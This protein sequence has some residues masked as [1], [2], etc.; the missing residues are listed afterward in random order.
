MCGVASLAPPV[1]RLPRWW[2]ITSVRQG[3]KMALA[4]CA[5]FYYAL[6][7]QFDSPGWCIF[8][9]VVLTLAQYVGAIAEKSALRAIGTVA[10]AL[11]GVWLIG[12]HG[13]NPLFVMIGC[14]VMAA[15]GT[16]MFGGNF[17]PYVFFLSALTTVVVVNNSMK[18]PS[19]AWPIGVARVEE[20]CVGILASMIV[21]SVLWPRYARVEFRN[22]FRAALRDTGRIAI[23]RSKALLEKDASDAGEE[24][25]KKLELSFTTRMN[26][27]RLLIRYGQRE[28]QYFRRKLP[29]RMRMMG[30]LG[31]C[32]E[33][34]VSLG[35]RLPEKS[36]YRDLIAG[37]L[38]RLHE[39]LERE[40]ED[41][42]THADEVTFERVNPA[43]LEAAGEC[44]RRLRE[45]IGQGATRSIPIQE[46]MDFSAHMVALSDIVARL[47]VLRECAW[48][49]HQTREVMAPTITRKPER[50]KL[51]AFWI[52][53]GIKG[54]ITATLALLY[55]NW[56][57]PPGGATI[58]FAAWL[59]TAL[60]RTYPGGQGD[61]GAFAYVVRI[62]LAGL[63]Y[64]ALL[65]VVTPFLADYFVFN[66][67]LI[68][69]L[70]WLG[71]SIAEQGGI[72]LYAQTG[73]LFFVGTISANPQEPV[74]FQAI[75][76]IYFGVVIA[77]VLS[78]FIQRLLWPLL[79]QREIRRLFAEY[80]ACCRALLGQAGEKER[81]R[82]LD[83]IA[84]IP[85]EAASWIKVTTTPEYPP[86]ETQ[87]LL[88]LL[89]TAQRLGYSIVS[90]HKRTTVEIPPELWKPLEAGVEHV[91]AECR[92]ALLILEEAFAQGRHGRAPDSQ[93]PIFGCLN[94]P[95][96]SLR[97]RYLTGEVQFPQA[98]P[99]L[100][101]MD[102]FEN[103]SRKIDQCAAQ[104]KGL[105]LERYSGDYAL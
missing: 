4:G 65:L 44:D 104:L 98:I 81:E 66:M 8:T 10:G 58:P 9:V 53:N 55:V 37:E 75:A 49:I 41:L 29:V 22:A 87:K 80:F 38:L 1:E 36:R 95:L 23:A 46:A 67:F 68:I 40:F 91:E 101:A 88:D 31:A 99:F 24:E 86:G 25:M 78:S 60:S 61:R 47:K 70:F 33:A 35:Q 50:F 76:N 32:F 3:L 54:G 45:L 52:R 103:C 59:F 72:S 57:N 15:F 102:F 16:A 71:Y 90:A 64:A 83:R 42:T 82:L 11:V 2:E 21:T 13:N 85:S 30:E 97:Q 100:G 69:G 92:K 73:M 96:G 43:L 94:E 28:S 14:F 84:L 51:D 77:L 27:M 26:Q 63:P 89:H 62:A 17:Y 18:D 79:P 19:Q 20:I 7:Q 5:A 93:M 74:G 12:C 105:A 56:I 48:E 39:Q 34:A 6:W